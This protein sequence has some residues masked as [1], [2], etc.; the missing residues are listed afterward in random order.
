MTARGTGLQS[1]NLP[2]TDAGVYSNSVLNAAFTGAPDTSVLRFNAAGTLPTNFF[3]EVGTLAANGT[4]VSITDPGVFQ[5]ELVTSQVAGVTNVWG[6]S[7]GAVTQPLTAV[8]A[9]GVDGCF[10]RAQQITLA[11]QTISV[12]MTGIVLMRTAIAKATA[13]LTA[14]NNIRGLAAATGGGAPTGVVA[15]N[16]SLR[17]AKM[18][19]TSI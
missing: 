3:S 13:G 6:L 8:P 2:L 4:V 7:F 18:N 14:A 16:V 9:F 1:I 5:V 15:A 10:Q 17:I 11:G 12:T 19:F